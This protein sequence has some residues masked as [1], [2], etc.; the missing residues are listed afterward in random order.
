MVDGQRVVER[1]E[2][3][4]VDAFRSTRWLN[5]TPPVILTA[6]PG[7]G[8]RMRL[9][10]E[11]GEKRDSLELTPEAPLSTELW[12]APRLLGVSSGKVKTHRYGFPSVS[13]DGEPT[14]AYATLTRAKQGV[15]VEEIERS[16]GGKK[17]KVGAET[18][19][20]NELAV[21]ERG[22]TTKQVSPDAIFE[23]VLLEGELAA[24]AAAKARPR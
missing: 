10:L 14:L 24:P 5:G 15:V 17:R 3:G 4:V 11:V 2:Q 9:K 23:R 7:E 1:D 8:G 20:R 6:K 16:S 19:V 21:D 22:F 12:E 13:E 18:P